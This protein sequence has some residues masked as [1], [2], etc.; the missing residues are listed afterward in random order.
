[1]AGLHGGGVPRDGWAPLD[2][3]AGGAALGSCGVTLSWAAYLSF[4]EGLLGRL[5]AS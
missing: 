3:E 4:L 1:M 5:V 2:G